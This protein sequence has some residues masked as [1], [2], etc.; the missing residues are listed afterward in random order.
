MLK[1]ILTEKSLK[2][3]KNNKYTFMVPTTF[4]KGQ[5]KSLV[6][7]TFKV[8]V[9][10]IATINIKGGTK[11]T[12]RGIIKTIKPVKKAIVETVEK[13]DLFEEKK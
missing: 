3:A 1:P 11:R 4:T 8:K 6:A 13:L 12:A 10:G 7:K 5:I 9:L 2:E